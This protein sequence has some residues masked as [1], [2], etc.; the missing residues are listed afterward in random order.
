MP[1]YDPIG[2]DPPSRGR[3]ESCDV[4]LRR[5]HVSKQH[6]TVALQ[7]VAARNG[8]VLTIQDTSA[9][10]TWVNGKRLRPKVVTPLQLGDRISFLPE[11]HEFYQDSLLYEVADGK[12][13]DA[14]GGLQ[15]Q[16]QLASSPERR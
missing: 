4:M 13:A 10:G 11:N 1:D 8:H 9:N 3:E 14:V 5:A 7:A 12:G 6:A 2:R 15:P 16:P